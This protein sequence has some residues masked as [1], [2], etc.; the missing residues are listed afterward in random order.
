MRKSGPSST[1]APSLR[2]SVA[3][4][5]IR[6]VSFTRQLP[7]LRSR[8]GPSANNA[9]PP[10]SWPHRESSSNPG[11]RHA[12][13]PFAGAAASIQ[14]SPISIRAPI[15]ASALANSTSPWML[16]R[17]DSFDADRTSAYCTR[18]K[19]IRSTRRIAFDE[20]LARTLQATSGRDRERRPSFTLD[21]HAETRHQIECNVDV[22]FGDQVHPPPRW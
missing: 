9:P 11:R 6:S 3:I 10:A 19:K 4:A 12:V 1:V 20:D 17:P 7:I 8:L 15:R 21:R 16:P 14:F 22:G 5:A 18:G 2:N 13:L